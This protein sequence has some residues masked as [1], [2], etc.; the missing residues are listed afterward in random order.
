MPFMRYSLALRVSVEQWDLS[1][2]ITIFL[3]FMKKALAILA[4]T[5]LVLTSCFNSTENTK[6]ENLDATSEK[7][8]SEMEKTSTKKEVV[9]SGDTVEVDYVGTLEDGTVFDASIEE[10]AKKTKNYSPD[11]GR[12]YEPL[13]FTVGAGQMI[14]GF[15]S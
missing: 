9:S 13:S 8:S 15:D 11:S 14:K 5:P 12:K 2:F 7:V 4:I 10:F 3:S 1:L 6:T